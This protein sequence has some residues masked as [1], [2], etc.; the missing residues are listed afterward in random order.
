[1]APE[2]ASVITAV[3]A[4]ISRA[5]RTNTLLE[6]WIAGGQPDKI[7]FPEHA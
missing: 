4:M 2:R 6:H 3:A 7:G 5:Q 1:M